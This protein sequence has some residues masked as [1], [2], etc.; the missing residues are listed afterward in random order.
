MTVEE[1]LR[2]MLYPDTFEHVVASAALPEFRANPKAWWD[3]RIKPMLR[4]KFDRLK[5]KPSTDAALWTELGRLT[6]DGTD[7]AKWKALSDNCRNK[8]H[9]LARRPSGGSFA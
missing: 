2:R 1:Y 5:K 3:L 9:Q 6:A 8:M 7:G 4:A